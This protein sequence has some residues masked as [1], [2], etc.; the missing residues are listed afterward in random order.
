M[1]LSA[2]Y[3]GEKYLFTLAE[4]SEDGYLQHKNQ[5]QILEGA[6]VGQFYGRISYPASAVTTDFDFI[7]SVFIEFLETGNVCYESMSL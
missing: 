7:K 3:D 6:K 2:E 5:K 1:E 4:Y